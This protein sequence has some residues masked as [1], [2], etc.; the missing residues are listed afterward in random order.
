MARVKP[1][2]QRKRLEARQ[3]DYDKMAKSDGAF[4]RPGSLSK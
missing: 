2:K 1:K 4:K 3:R